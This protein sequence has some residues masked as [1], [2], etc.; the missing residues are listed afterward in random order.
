MS[1]NDEGPRFDELGLDPRVM[2]VLKD[3]GLV[4][5][6]QDGTRRIYQVDAAGLALLRSHL[7]D[8]WERSLRALQTVAQPEEST[9]DAPTA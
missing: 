9:D 2:K 7:D 6:R 8:F 4:L 1:E 5:D 3:V